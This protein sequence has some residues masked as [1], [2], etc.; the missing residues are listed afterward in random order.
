[1]LAT[2]KEGRLATGLD[3]IVLNLRP[4]IVDVVGV[5]VFGERFEVY[6]QPRLGLLTAQ[7]GAEASLYVGPRDLAEN[8]Q[9]GLADRARR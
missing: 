9:L 5:F 4:P 7:R 1:M 6:R 3:P 2:G 8:Y